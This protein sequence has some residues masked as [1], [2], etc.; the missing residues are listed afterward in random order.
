MKMEFSVEYCFEG[1]MEFKKRFGDYDTIKKFEERVIKL[2]IPKLSYLFIKNVEGTNKKA[3]TKIILTS[4]D[5]KLLYET[6]KIKGVNTIELSKA[7]VDTK[8][9]Y[10]NFLFAKDVKEANIYM[11]EDV[12]VKSNNNLFK[13]Y[14]AK[15]VFGS[16]KRK[17]GESV[18]TGSPNINYHFA[19][20]IKDGLYL[21]HLEVVKRDK[22]LYELL[23]KTM[24]TKNEE[25]LEKQRTMMCKDARRVLRRLDYIVE[26]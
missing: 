1:I 8:D 12:I 26:K 20:D 14:F 5:P 23:I 3:H 21:Q 15:D 18:L 22:D 6:A 7:I 11:H 13:Y 17:L 24:K 25:D 9:A 16:D 2:G 4:N 10:Y 19:T